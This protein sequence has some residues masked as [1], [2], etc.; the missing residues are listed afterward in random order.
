MSKAFW[1]DLRVLEFMDSLLRT[2]GKTAVYFMLAT[3]APSG[4]HPDWVRAWEAEYGWPVDHRAENGDLVDQEVS[5][6]NGTLEP[7]NQ[8]TQNVRAV[9]VNQFGWDRGRCGER[10][11]ADMTFADIRRG[12]DLEFGQSVYEPFGIAQL[13]PLGY[14]ALSCLSNVCGCV[15]FVTRVVGESDPVRQSCSGRLCHVA[16]GLLVGKSLRRCGN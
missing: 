8:R 12:T 10:M 16:S 13:E 6:F 7:F 2:E 14:G 9:F 1:R 3:I 5:F 15:G 11:P 4:R